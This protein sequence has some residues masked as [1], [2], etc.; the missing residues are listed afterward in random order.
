M[1]LEGAC[2]CAAARET[3]AKPDSTKVIKE[4][5]VWKRLDEKKGNK[6]ERAVH[7]VRNIFLMVYGLPFNS[8][9]C[10]VNDRSKLV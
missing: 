4:R 3:M 5:M 9:F 7:W 6:K 8:D 2:A 1:T 10:H